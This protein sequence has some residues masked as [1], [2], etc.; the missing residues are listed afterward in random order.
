MAHTV[1]QLIS[2][3]GKHGVTVQSHTDSHIEVITQFCKDGLSFTEVET[4]SANL[5]SVREYLGY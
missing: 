3:I 4:I 1:E 5:Q 2:A